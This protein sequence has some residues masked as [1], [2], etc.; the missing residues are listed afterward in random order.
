M[1]FP[2]ELFHA[3]LLRTYPREPEIAARYQALVESDAYKRRGGFNHRVPAR[4]KKRAQTPIPPNPPG[5]NPPCPDCGG[6]SAKNGKTPQ[7]KQTYYCKDRKCKRNFVG[8]RAYAP[9]PPCIKCGSATQKVGER[10]SD[11]Q[12]YRCTDCTHHFTE[13]F[14]EAINHAA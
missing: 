1:N 3:H 4:R 13:R 14:S 10:K 12:S 8:E 11:R 5:V 6:P 2:Q 7:G 9:N